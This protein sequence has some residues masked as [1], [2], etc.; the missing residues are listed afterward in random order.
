MQGIFHPSCYRTTA[1]ISTAAIEAAAERTAALQTGNAD[2]LEAMVNNE[3]GADVQVY[4]LTQ[5]EKDALAQA[6]QSVYDEFAA[7]YDAQADID[8]IKALAD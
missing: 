6:A 4:E 5:E 7:K 3:K 2:A 1:A 8:A